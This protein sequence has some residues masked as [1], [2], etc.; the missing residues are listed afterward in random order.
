MMYLIRLFRF[1]A[2]ASV[3]AAALAGPLPA[4]QPPRTSSIYVEVD[5]E[6]DQGLDLAKSLVAKGQY[7]RAVK[8][9][10]RILSNPKA[11]TYL[12]K[13]GENTYQGV[14]RYV[15]GALLSLP[16]EARRKYLAHIDPKARFDYNHAASK[17]Q[18]PLL[19]EVFRTH[20]NSSWGDNALGAIARFRFERA[21]Y[22]GCAACVEQLLEMF[23][24]TDLKTAPLIARLAVCYRQL[25]D[26]AALR[27]L[28]SSLPDNAA[29]EQINAGTAPCTL[30]AFVNTVLPAMELRRSAPD[31]LWLT[32][33]G[34][35]TRAKFTPDVEPAGKP[36]WRATLAQSESG[37]S[38]D[39][40]VILWNNLLFVQSSSLLFCV[41]VG[42]GKLEWV[43][44]L[45]EPEDYFRFE[46]RP[47][48]LTLQDGRLFV[49]QR[50][51]RIA[52][53]DAS[54]GSVIWRS[55]AS[56][57]NAVLME[58]LELYGP[59]LA[60]EDRVYACAAR[61]TETTETYVCCFDSRDGRLR[62][63]TF[64]A[65]SRRGFGFPRRLPR[66]VQLYPGTATATIA[67]SAN[68]VFCLTN[69]GALAAVCA[70]TGE[71]LWLRTYASTANRAPV[72][73]RPR[74][75][76]PAPPQGHLKAK[77]QSLLVCGRTVVAAP[78]D[79]NLL[80]GL[81]PL[82]GSVLWRLDK[83]VPDRIL[84]G[85]FETLFG[86]QGAT[87]CA[88]SVETGKQVWTSVLPD[89]AWASKVSAC[90]SESFLH[91]LC[92]NTVLRLKTAGG[93][94]D[95][96]LEIEAC[97]GRPLLCDKGMI[98]ASGTCAV[99]L[100]GEGVKPPEP[101]MTVTDK[102][103]VDLLIRALA[104][105]SYG[106]RHAAYRILRRRGK[107]ILPQLEAAEASRDAEVAWRAAEIAR[108]KRRLIRIAQLEKI[109]TAFVKEN[110]PHLL[111][112]A[113]DPDYRVRHHLLRSVCSACKGP[114]LREIIPFLKEFLRDESSVVRL[115][116]ALALLQRADTSGSEE[117]E[118]ALASDSL[119]V[120]RNTVTLL[121]QY[122]SV[123]APLLVRALGDSDFQ[124]RLSA[125][126]G[127]AEGGTSV[128][129]KELGELLRKDNMAEIRLACVRALVTCG[130]ELSIP[131]IA[132]AIADKSHAVRV[133]AVEELANM[134]SHEAARTLAGALADT[135]ENISRFAAESM[136]EYAGPAFN[137]VV[138]QIAKS[139][140]DKRKQVRSYA[141]QLLAKTGTPDAVN[142]LVESLSDPD[143]EL[144]EQVAEHVFNMA[145]KSAVTA[146]AAKAADKDARVRYFAV[147]VLA[148]IA[149]PEC[150]LPLLAAAGDAKEETAE[151]ARKT[152]TDI[153]K[154]A[155]IPDAVGMR[156]G[157]KS[158]AV[159]RAVRS[160]LGE[161]PGKVLIP[162]LIDTLETSG[163]DAQ[164][165]ALKM[166][167]QKTG[168]E[169]G[170][171][172]DK[173]EKVRRKAVVRWREWWIKESVPAKELKRILSNL[174]SDV[175]SERWR[176]A[177]KAGKLK[178]RSV[179]DALTDSLDEELAW[180][181][182]AKIGALRK[183]TGKSFGYK[184]GLTPEKVKTV[185]EKWRKWW[186]Q[187]RQDY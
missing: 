32:Q 33:G 159:R 55:F 176:A 179:I 116:A 12:R 49:L 48:R 60:T 1:T 109:A 41:D 93:A 70:R 19:E 161:L 7:D 38:S 173:G 95:A 117:I 21:D 112:R 152:L 22:A 105:P 61:G 100:P 140:K 40:D 42:T 182:K 72:R 11:G 126:N 118:S 90:L 163:R 71:I 64:I 160:L 59:I 145:D 89:P 58:Q 141:Q 172:P 102:S 121:A 149:I 10:E 123:A 185:K 99:L 34:D 139:L 171:H 84:C 73:P 175:P 39:S 151:L 23:E 107:E 114:A 137:S 94:L 78:A 36:L 57:E 18:E 178:T 113:T 15:R 5:A 43:T 138:G 45:L 9:Y 108:D 124:V 119:T 85:S 13:Q 101:Q 37:P 167:K 154:P 157:H 166:L 2:V 104:S 25:G 17:M 50:P 142:A 52:A 56:G 53:V 8:I 156:V 184:D 170:F 146:L 106:V 186:S 77:S 35:N 143:R 111:V 147:Q 97:E 180:V 169:F 150:V 54:T 98:I 88:V 91:L 81:R 174:K 155:D 133:A 30:R 51:N 31:W 63:I 24:Q 14:L 110:V 183:L 136:Y 44:R 29:Q 68:T 153:M 16:G 67:E 131:L 165:H 76:P 87:V 129:L 83:D 20:C 135:D 96:R 168:K 4:Q 66:P 127:L 86:M 79:A 6:T 128:A 125:V 134:D 80:M 148:R 130:N 62:W 181:L 47:E 27:K 120:R 82:D 164:L 162:G 92:E 187:A 69:T 46:G 65:A 132:P 74:V 26:S 103:D 144:A 115:E 177:L 75:Q 122:S 28:S 158:E 3:L